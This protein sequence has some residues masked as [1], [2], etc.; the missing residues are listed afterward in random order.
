MKLTNQHTLE[1]NDQ[2]L[3]ALATKY[4]DANN[5][6]ELNKCYSNAK[7]KQPSAIPHII[8]CMQSIVLQNIKNPTQAIMNFAP[9]L[10]FDDLKTVVSI[11]GHELRLTCKNCTWNP[12]LEFDLAIDYNGGLVKFTDLLNLL[13]RTKSNIKYKYK[14]WSDTLSLNECNSCMH[15]DTGDSIVNKYGVQKRST[16]DVYIEFAAI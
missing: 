9:V 2:S 8:D 13:R 12:N 11:E 3:S 6:P 7:T 15:L 4:K 14:K 10:A 1:I 5:W 16:A